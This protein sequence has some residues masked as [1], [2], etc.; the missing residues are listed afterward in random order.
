MAAQLAKCD[1]RMLKMT[2][3]MAGVNLAVPLA[4]CDGKMANMTLFMPGEKWL[5]RWPNV[6][7]RLL[8]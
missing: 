2:L 1:E 3:L 4:K 8:I 7:E 6:T 5:H